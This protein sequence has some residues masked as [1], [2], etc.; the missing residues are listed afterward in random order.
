MSSE[1]CRFEVGDLVYRTEPSGW[2]EEFGRMDRVYRVTK[3]KEDGRFSH[4]SIIDIDSGEEFPKGSSIRYFDLYQ[5][6]SSI[7]EPLDGDLI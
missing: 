7:T 6:V 5:S 1:K 3:F 2:P 4:I